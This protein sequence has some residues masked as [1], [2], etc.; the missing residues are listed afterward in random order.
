[1][2][3]PPSSAELAE[4]KAKLK[5]QG[6]NYVKVPPYRGDFPVKTIGR[7]AVPYEHDKKDF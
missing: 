4:I 5:E 6:V 7:K 1:M 2:L 3:G